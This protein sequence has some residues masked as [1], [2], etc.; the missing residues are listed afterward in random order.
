MR[1]WPGRKG[2]LGILLAAAAGSVFLLAVSARGQKHDVDLLSSLARLREL[3]LSVN[4]QLLLLRYG[5]SVSY[6]QVNG[7]L[8]RCGELLCELASRLPANADRPVP[9]SAGSLHLA[10]ELFAAKRADIEEFQ[11]RNASLANSMRFF[12]RAV[13]GLLDAAR[14]AAA[15]D[16]ESEA[17]DVAREV[18]IAAFR[19]DELHAGD[20]AARVARLSA[21]ALSAEAGL[22]RAI[23][24]F[25]V[26]ARI[27]L[28]TRPLVDGLLAKILAMPI[29]AEI[30][31]AERTFVK[32]RAEAAER[33][34]RA[35]Y[36][37]LLAAAGLL[38]LAGAIA[39]HV[40]RTARRLAEAGERLSEQSALAAEVVRA[41]P[42]SVFI[43]AANGL[44]VS[45]NEAAERL[46]DARAGSLVGADFASMLRHGEEASCHVLPKFLRAILERGGSA[47]GVHLELLSG[48]GSP[49]PIAL[50]VAGL[51]AGHDSARIAVCVARDMR[52]PQRSVEHERRLAASEAAADRARARTRELEAERAQAERA[53]RATGELIARASHELRAP[54]DGLMGLTERLLASGVCGEAREL[55]RTIRAGGRALVESV[56]DILDSAR[57]DAEC[58][59]L[60]DVEFECAAVLDQVLDAFGATAEQRGIALAA[61]LRGD[62]AARLRGDPVRVRRVLTHLVGN[63]LESVERGHVLVRAEAEAAA[64]RFVVTVED[65]GIG[66]APDAIEGMFER[67]GGRA[68]PAA[69]GRGGS[70]L[71]LPISRRLA[72]AMGGDLCASHRIGGGSAFRF[73]LPA[74]LAAAPA[75]PLPRRQLGVHLECSHAVEAQILRGAL[76]A[77]GLSEAGTDG[78][79]WVVDSG[80]APAAAGVPPAAVLRIV[81][82]AEPELAAAG[83]GP[84]PMLRRPLRS[85]RACEALRQLAAPPS[86]CASAP[87]VPAAHANVARVLVAEDNPVNQKVAQRMLQRLHCTVVLANN[88]NEAVA[89]VAGGGIDLVLMDCQMP[90]CDGYE[91]TKRI[92]AGESFSRVPIVALTASTM[93]GD[94]EHCRAVG[95]DGYLSKPVH[96]EALRE[97]LQRFA[98]AAVQ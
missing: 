62:P 53:S 61:E 22:A 55:A 12:P 91:A 8:A 50:S 21:Q 51:A 93:P 1:C 31:A 23:Q 83:E 34:R 15:A 95:M 7:D 6:D 88:G 43:V 78:Q 65:T 24:V 72:R 82:A 46:V 60:A 41:M 37:L 3:D 39:V 25:A 16:V 35:R 66:F 4:E 80:A 87:E 90:E 67:C 97:T 9:A 56:D 13:Q 63:A 96:A 44:V 28:T 81:G 33:G 40:R 32:A 84:R 47:T 52:S 5:L 64:G 45:A 27:L 70:G 92:R 89:A 71:G 58:L 19:G 10:V 75:L 85:W 79:L 48:G 73:E 69:S 17:G 2:L 74:A 57:L 18:L 20:L 14:A 26:H 94:E 76:A 68:R 98:S 59:E 86:V 11:S 29:G 36:G 77:L 38:A 49:V 30:S 54:L 42:D